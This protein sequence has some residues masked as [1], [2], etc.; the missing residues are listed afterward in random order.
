[1][2]FALVLLLFYQPVAV[3]IYDF[4]KSHGI[5]SRSLRLLTSDLFYDSHRS[6]LQEILLRIL[7]EQPFA[8]RGINADYLVLGTYAHNILLEFLYEFGF[9]LGSLLLLP[10]LVAS[11]KTIFNRRFTIK[12][13]FCVMLFFISIPQH[14]VSGSIWTSYVFWLWLAVLL[15]KAVL[16]AG[17]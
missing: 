8:V 3:W 2:V 11:Y 7:L 17:E 6:E 4:L 15:N 12:E 16:S 9:L 10:I 13:Q 1:M 14:F 5:S